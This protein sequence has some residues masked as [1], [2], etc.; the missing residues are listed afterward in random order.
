MTKEGV[1]YEFLFVFLGTTLGRCGF[2]TLLFRYNKP[3]MH[4]S[5]RPDW[6]TYKERWFVQRYLNPLTFSYFKL[7]ACVSAKHRQ[8]C[9]ALYLR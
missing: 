6:A 1:G 5:P 2:P 4:S 3:K 7:L 8:L 9:A